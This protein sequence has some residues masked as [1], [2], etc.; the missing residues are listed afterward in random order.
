M[1]GKKGLPT[2]RKSKKILKHGEI[3]GKELT[4][5]QKGL[6]GLIAGG[7]KPSRVKKTAKR[8]RKRAR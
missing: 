7:G 8:R 6:F 4:G 1:A 3:R 2:K 5:A